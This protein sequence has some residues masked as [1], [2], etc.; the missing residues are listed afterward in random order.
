VYARSVRNDSYTAGTPSISAVI[1][2]ADAT[3]INSSTELALIGTTGYPLT[4]YYILEGDIDMTSVT[5]TPKGTSAS[6]FTGVFDGN[7]YEITNLT[8][9]GTTTYRGLFGYVSSGT[10]KNVTLTGANISGG[11]HT[12]AVAGYLGS[13]GVIEYCSVSGVVQGTSNVGG[14]VGQN[15][16]TV[17]YCYSE[18]N[19]TGTTSVGGIVGAHE[20][21]SSGVNNCYS[22]GTVTGTATAENNVGGIVGFASSTC[23]ILNSYSTGAIIGS[24]TNVGGILGRNQGYPQLQN[25]VVLGKSITGSSSVNRVSGNTPNLSNNRARSDMTVNGDLITTGTATN[26]NGLSITSA[27]WDVQSFWETTMGWNFTTIWEW[28]GTL[29]ILRGF[30]N[31]TQNPVV[32]P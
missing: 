11:Q 1:T 21:A 5:W 13:A 29:P 9:S 7:G 30:P 10:V 17:R 31:V 4:D 3:K 19:V 27:D 23:T 12:G 24:G 14:I 6:P 2:T 15:Y 22:T 8:I 26:S 28:N 32:V 16:G 25:C 20:V 18:A